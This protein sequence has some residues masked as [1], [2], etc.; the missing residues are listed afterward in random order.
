[1]RKP[2]QLFGV[3]FL[4]VG[5]LSACGSASNE[6]AGQ[7]QTNAG[8]S[9]DSGSTDKE[10]LTIGT[11]GVYKPFS[12]KNLETGK[13]TG[14]DVEVAREVAK[15]IDMEPKF[16]PTPWKSMFASLNSKRF[17]MIA[18][19]VGITKERKENYAFSVPYTYSGA[20][21]I[22]NKDNTTI[23]G[24]EDLKGK[25]VGTTRGSNYAKYAKEAGA[26][27]KYYKGIG[28]V[29]KDLSLKRVDAALNDRLFILTELDESK[30]DVK[31]VGDVFHE[32][33]MAFAF[34][35]EGSDQLVKKVN[36]AI[37]A[38]KE[39]GT[40]AEISKKWFGENVSER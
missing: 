21:V 3:F 38:M 8:E 10:V 14:Y 16:V 11:E 33:K 9:T 26:K 25:V 22:V 13:L 36:K 5:M 2:L 12:F 20:R 17:D 28:Q 29:L 31:A 39:D 34:R 23:K 32:V 4:V 40:L 19:Q 15:R 35:Q 6:G 30:F 24:I 27:V 1:M 7:N 18:N 37:K